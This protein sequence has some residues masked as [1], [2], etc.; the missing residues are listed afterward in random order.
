[1]TKV[2]I[3]GLGLIGGS[4]AK[5]LKEKH[6]KKYTVYALTKDKDDIKNALFDGAIDKGFTE[7]L[8]N[9]FFDFDVVILCV[10]PNII[11]KT[12]KALIPH[13]PKNTVYTDVGSIKSEIAEEMRT[14]PVTYVGGHPMAGTEKKGYLHSFPHL[15]E[16][17]YYFLM[18]RNELVEQMVADLGAN[19]IFT[20]CETHDKTVAVISHIPHAV[21]ASLVNLAIENE[22]ADKMLSKA[23]AGGFRD[24]TRISSSSEN[25]WESIL[26]SNKKYVVPLLNEMTA[27]LDGLKTDIINNDSEN[28][29]KFFRDARLYRNELSEN[30]KPLHSQYYDIYISVEDK[31]G[32]IAKISEILTNSNISIQNIGILKSREQIGGTLILSVYT[33]DDYKKSMKL[34]KENGFDITNFEE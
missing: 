33:L 11:A 15:F 19:A 22:T 26:L 25:L 8:P 24:T 20:S 34:L 18:Q 29:L 27:L 16:N 28:I 17:A 21:S 31:V 7:I 4:I 2:F 1:M 10:P 3:A 13:F 23:A 30:R 32:V 5:R 6:G 9:D 12:A 14:L